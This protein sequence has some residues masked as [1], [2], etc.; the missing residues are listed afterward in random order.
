MPDESVGRTA[1]PAYAW[2]VIAVLMVLNVSSFIDR[3]VIALMVTPIKADLG[4]SDTEMGLLLGPAFAVTFAVAV[5]L[6]GPLVD[7][8]SRRAII[9]WGVAFWSV[10]CTAAGVANTFGQLFAT[11]VGV[12]VGEATLSPSAYS[13]IADYFPPRRLATA[14]SVFTSGVFIGAGLAYLIGGLL[15]G[16]LEGAE[17]WVI[18]AVGQVRPWQRVFIVLG[19]A[20]LALTFLV[21][22]IREPARGRMQGQR[23]GLPFGPDDARQ[24]AARH[25]RAYLTFGLGIALFAIVN[26]ATAF[27][28]PSYFER[29]HEWG[30]A[31]IVVYMGGTT[32]VFGTLG[33]LAGG[34]L[35]DWL[36]TRGRP[37]GNLVLLI[38]SALVSVAAGLPLFLA[39]SEPVLI[40][41]LVVTNIVAAAP[42]GAAA[43]AA[44]EMTPAPMR[45]KASA[46]LIFL[47]N[48][49]GLGL[50]PPIAAFLT[51]SVFRDPGLIGLSL[52]TVTI[53]GR[54]LAA[55]LV[56][57]GLSSHRRALVEVV[58]T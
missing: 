36:K 47:L 1:S 4:L 54:G 25:W 45:G 19:L 53:V 12:G 16:A 13:L 40:L 27:W 41:A 24:W 28:F 42:F 52:L 3:Q 51:D 56:G 14:M 9:G 18:P 7:R 57:A 49:I 5:I 43:A 21:L 38:G 26:Y 20:G 10:M 44:Q 11:R 8:V 17:P 15:V 55:I 22:T 23:A 33:V 32:A 58:Q 50:G 29:A 2:Y 31:K 34:R 46:V 37:D 35:A 39:K 30:P 6:V 48:F